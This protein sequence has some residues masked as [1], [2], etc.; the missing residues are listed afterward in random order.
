MSFVGVSMWMLLKKYIYI[1]FH[2]VW[3]K[4]KSERKEEA[5]AVIF[6]KNNIKCIYC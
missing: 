5:R 1:C 4:S 3:L 6:K 2:N